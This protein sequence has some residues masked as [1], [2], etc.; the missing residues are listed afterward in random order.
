MIQHDPAFNCILFG[1][2]FFK[3]LIFNCEIM[4]KTWQFINSDFFVPFL[5]E[6]SVK[7]VSAYYSALTNITFI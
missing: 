2:V 7:V 3:V 5:V 4:Y 6:I 1:F